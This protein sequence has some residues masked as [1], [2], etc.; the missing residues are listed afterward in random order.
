MPLALFTLRAAVAALAAAS[1]AP[2][3]A[4]PGELPAGVLGVALI[5]GWRAADDA[6]VAAIEIRLAPGWY[7]YWRSPGDTGVPPRFDWSA[8]SNLADVRYDWPRPRVF[9]SFGSRAI[10]YRD[11]LV[12]PVVLTPAT[13]G[14]TIEA[15]VDLF[16]GVCDDICVPAEAR[17][18]ARLAP[19]GAPE[20]H[21]VIEAARADG[22]LD[23]AAAGVT[24]ARCVLEPGPDGHHIAAEVTFATPPGAIEAA[25][26]EADARPDLW[27]GAAE[28]RVEGRVVHAAAP[29]AALGD[30]GVAL[31]RGALRLTLFEAGRAV[32]LEGCAGAP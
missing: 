18:T 23:A 6:H 30:G 13:P 27:I 20:G 8:S 10:G 31:D 29:L 3:A 17:L 26:I 1:A 11:A 4:A 12:L 19:D 7:T 14:A 28:A 32:E 24:G 2:A 25:V 22:T 5:P 16:F 15:T 9:D 21:A